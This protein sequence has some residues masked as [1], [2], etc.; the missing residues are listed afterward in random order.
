[1]KNHLPPVLL[2]AALLLAAF[3]PINAVQLTS[4]TNYAT[5]LNA[6]QERQPQ[7]EEYDVIVESS[8]PTRY[9][10]LNSPT[11]REFYQNFMKQC[12]EK[13]GRGGY[14]CDESERTRLANNLYQPEN[15]KVCSY[16]I[17]ASCC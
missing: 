4:L 1:M 17:T 8:F 10:I 11:R 13:M 3:I 15:M 16:T 5:S 6:P 7:T 2:L 12:R 14:L 9:K